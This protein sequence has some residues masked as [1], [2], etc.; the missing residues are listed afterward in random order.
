MRS[1]RTYLKR[2]RANTDAKDPDQLEGQETHE[3]EGRLVS[4]SEVPR[5]RAAWNTRQL[6]TRFRGVELIGHDGKPYTQI[7]PARQ[8][9]IR[10]EEHHQGGD[11]RPGNEDEVAAHKDSA[12]SEAHTVTG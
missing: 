4:L 1:A 2:K 5:Q 8:H 9:Q 6:H 10:H 3:D 11:T 7:L 12:G